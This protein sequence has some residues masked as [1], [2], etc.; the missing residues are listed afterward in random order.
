MSAGA[1][2]YGVV[3]RQVREEARRWELGRLSPNTVIN[4]YRLGLVR[5][6]HVARSRH[7]IIR[8]P[9]R[10]RGTAA[11]ATSIPGAQGRTGGTLLGAA[12]RSGRSGSAAGTAGRAQ[13]EPV[14]LG[15]A[16]G[17]T[18]D[19]RPAPQHTGRTL[20]HAACHT[21][22]RQN[23]ETAARAWARPAPAAGIPSRTRLWSR[24]GRL[25]RTGPPRAISLGRPSRLQ[26]DA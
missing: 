20:R 22:R 26:E 9:R 7:A 25:I 11:R 19:T 5:L 12:G 1:R 6:F 13:A 18:R 4:R 17:R 10:Q 3:R 15:S 21:R 24:P 23:R 2:R 14:A 16:P 8:Q